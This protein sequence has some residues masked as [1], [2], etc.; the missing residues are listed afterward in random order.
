MSKRGTIL[1]ERK[2]GLENV[3]GDESDVRESETRVRE[4]NRYRR[5]QLQI[6]RL[7]ERRELAAP[8]RLFGL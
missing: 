7:I 6:D 4:R 5:V 8:D 3:Q 1:R 2:E